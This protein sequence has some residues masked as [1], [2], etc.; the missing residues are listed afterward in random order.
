MSIFYRDRLG[1]YP[2]LSKD[3]HWAN[4][5]IPQLGDLAAHLA[6]HLAAVDW[7]EWRPLWERNLGTKVEYRRLS[8]WLARRERPDLSNGELAS[9]ARKEFEESAR[10]FMEET[11]RLAVRRRP[12]GLW[13]F[14]GFPF[15]SNWHKTKTGEAF[16]LSVTYLLFK[17]ISRNATFFLIWC[18]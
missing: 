4:G 12:K 5:G 3:G 16:T 1:K 17:F 9:V 6:A 10:K 13:G 15:F 7:E 8:K 2:Y 14:Y 18:V 11:L